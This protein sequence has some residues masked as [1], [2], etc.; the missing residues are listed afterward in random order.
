MEEG[1]MSFDMVF[2]FQ[3][4]TFAMIDEFASHVGKTLG[5]I[6]LVFCLGGKRL[7]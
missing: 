1:K 4:K 7:Y 3:A 2:L 5:E 6:G